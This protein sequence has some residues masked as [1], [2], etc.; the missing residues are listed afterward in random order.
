MAS[1][2]IDI[3][4]FDDLLNKANEKRLLMGS[5][6][7][8]YG[9]SRLQPQWDEYGNPNGMT[10]I[11]AS[12]PIWGPAIISS[13]EI[14]RQTAI[15]ENPVIKPQT[16]QPGESGGGLVV[17]DTSNMNDEIEGDFQITVL[18]DSE[19]HYFNFKRSLIDE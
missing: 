5:G 18:L 6:N 7:L 13:E 14:D 3:L 11:W 19:E 15:V 8:I 17:C 9:E 4:S 2:K 16:F 10:A 12:E 1:R